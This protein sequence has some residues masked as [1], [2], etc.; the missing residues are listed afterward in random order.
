MPGSPGSYAWPGREPWWDQPQ[1]QEFAST[2]TNRCPP[3]SLWDSPRLSRMVRAIA[4]ILQPFK[5]SGPSRAEP[6]R[7]RGRDV[8]GGPPDTT[9]LR[10]LTPALLKEETLPLLGLYLTQLGT[11]G[12][13]QYPEDIT[14]CPSALGFSTSGWWVLCVHCRMFSSTLGLCPLEASSTA[15]Y[16]PERSRRVKSVETK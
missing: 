6:W 16:D 15:G 13:V 8:E 2:S 9:R 4:M 10:F 3:P 11:R 1:S 12:R 7:D 14:C 5:P